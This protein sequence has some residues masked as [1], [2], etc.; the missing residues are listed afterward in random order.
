MKKIQTNYKLMEAQGLRA[1]S[2]M[3]F[4]DK[5]CWKVSLN[6]KNNTLVRKTLNCTA[7]STQLWQLI[8]L[9]PS[10]KYSSKE[11]TPLCSETVIF[12]PSGP[13]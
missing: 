3:S 4:F 12:Q 9:L 10:P 1:I 7:K 11:A 13:V 2:S 6:G 8:E 5:Y